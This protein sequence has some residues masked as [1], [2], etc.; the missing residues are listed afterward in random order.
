MPIQNVLSIKRL[1]LNSLNNQRILRHL[2]KRGCRP[3][4]KHKN[5]N[6]LAVGMYILLDNE[7]SDRS[8]TPNKGLDLYKNYRDP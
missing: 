8:I 6:K 1:T 3:Y 5:F 7:I 2:N 4:D